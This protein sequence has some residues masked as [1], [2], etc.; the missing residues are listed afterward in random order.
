MGY[1]NGTR[2]D[3]TDQLIV[4][5]I[6]DLSDLRRDV[7]SGKKGPEAVADAIAFITETVVSIRDAHKELEE[8]VKAVKDYSRFKPLLAWRDNTTDY[9]G[10]DLLGLLASPHQ[11]TNKHHPPP[12]ELIEVRDEFVKMSDD[13]RWDIV[14]ALYLWASLTKEKLAKREAKANRKRQA[15]EV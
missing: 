5:A 11:Y 6:A 13:E 14:E 8:P 12:Q 7:L 3:K 4:D 1:Q 2:P 9:W 15:N 10:E